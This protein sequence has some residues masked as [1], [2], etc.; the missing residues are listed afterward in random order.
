MPPMDIK[1]RPVTT[2]PLHREA[3]PGSRRAG[4]VTMVREMKT[5]WRPWVSPSHRS[6]GGDDTR[7]LGHRS[8]S[9]RA[10]CLP[11][12]SASHLPS[13]SQTPGSLLRDLPHDDALPRAMKRSW[14]SSRDNVAVVSNTLVWSTF[15]R[16]LTSLE[17]LL[18]R[19]SPALVHG[20]TDDIGDRSNFAASGRIRTAGVDLEP[21]MLGE[22]VSLHHAC[23]EGIRG[24]RLR[25]RTL[26]SERGS[27]SSSRPRAGPHES[28]CC[29]N[30]KLIDEM[31]AQRLDT[32]LLVFLGG[33]LDDPAV[34]ALGDL[35][36]RKRITGA[37][38]HSAHLRALIGHP[39]TPENL[40]PRYWTLRR[41]GCASLRG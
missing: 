7:S 36:T 41:A 10:A 3:L 34:L 17:R 15:V 39:K 16:N 23:H 11:R 32:T 6:H 26:P 31:V 4:D 13:G 5:I 38:N 19:F 33:I 1:V 24:S 28:S 18:A 30:R 22:G 2:P 14:R 21:F 37:G 25:C 40:E 20:G 8:E 27:Y 12:S 9:L 35:L 29:C